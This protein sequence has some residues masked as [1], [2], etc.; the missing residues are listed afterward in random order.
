M[1][2]WEDMDRGNLSQALCKLTRW[3]LSVRRGFTEGMSG[4]GLGN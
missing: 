2:Y 4:S 3:G 1:Y